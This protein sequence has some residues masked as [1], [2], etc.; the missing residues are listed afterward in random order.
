MIISV[1]FD[2]DVLRLKHKYLQAVDVIMQWKCMLL[3]GCNKCV[4]LFYY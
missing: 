1:G 3:G 4:K 2:E